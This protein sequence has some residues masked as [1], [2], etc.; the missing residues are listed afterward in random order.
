VLTVAFFL[1]SFFLDAYAWFF[2]LPNVIFFYL[3]LVSV[4]LTASDFTYCQTSPV[5]LSAAPKGKLSTWCK[6][7]LNYNP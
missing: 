3:W 6:V 1:L 7:I 5:Q 2:L 4:V